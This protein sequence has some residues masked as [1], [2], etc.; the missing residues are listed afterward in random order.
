MAKGQRPL[1]PP[2]EIAR[3]T[4]IAQSSAADPSAASLRQRAQAILQW[5]EGLSAGEVARRTTL[6]ENQVRYLWKLYQQK[7]LDLFMVDAEPIK[8]TEAA[9]TATQQAAAVAATEAPG[10]VTLEQ[11]YSEYKLDLPHAQ[12]IATTAL[13]LFEA[14]QNLHR[15]P[16]SARQLVEASALL[17]DIA[18]TVD[19]VNH[20]S[21]GRDMILAQPIRGFSLDEQRI[22]AAATAFHRKKPRLDTDPAYNALPADLK[23][24]ALAISAILR[25]ANGLDASQTHSTLIVGIETTTE[26]ILVLVDGPNAPDDADRAQTLSDLWVKAFAVPLRITVAHTADVPL[27]DRV[28]PEPSP[29]LTPRVTVVTAGRAF[30]LR[31]LDRVNALVTYLNADDLSVLPSLAREI[32]R[33]SE[34]AGLADAPDFKRE[35]GWMYEIINS[36]KLHATFIERLTNATE[37]SELLR[38]NAEQMISETRQALMQTLRGLE[39]KRYRALIADLRMVLTE[40]IDPNEKAL[41]AYNVGSL[42]W[43]QLTELR[44]I[45]E[46]SN[47]VEEALEA[48]RHLQD[49]LLAFRELLGAEVGQVLDMISPLES[50]LNNIG[51]AQTVLSR[52]QPKQVQVKKGR[53]TVTE[54]LELDPASQALRNTQAELIN[55]M[56]ESLPAV[57]N[58][59]SSS[60]FRRAFALAIASA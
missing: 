33:L 25:V 48:T 14:T 22:I 38:K 20:H 9:P 50:I 53:K 49:R 35:I 51:T 41:L 12:H 32:S 58:A 7:G 4:Q 1:L 16:D 43:E 15:L 30:A 26:E 36:A 21:K 3:L 6:S 60:L 56:A 42:L 8:P 45:M 52:L 24:D 40:D 28:L 10:T 57:W 34:A 2:D 47:S 31:T 13:Q 18:V 29:T 59:V 46:F 55:M 27:T 39:V 11:L 44:T 19:Q 5:H 54:E 17:H 23:R 37:D